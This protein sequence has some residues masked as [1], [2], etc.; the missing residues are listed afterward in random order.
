MLWGA[1]LLVATFAG[2]AAGVT[3]AGITILLI[4]EAADKHFFGGR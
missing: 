3:L 2:I 1:F 4:M